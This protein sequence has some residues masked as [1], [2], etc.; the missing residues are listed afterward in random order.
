LSTVEKIS[1]GSAIYFSG[2]ALGLSD[3]SYLFFIAT[4]PLLALLERLPIS[5]SAI[6]IREGLFVI[7]FAPFY[8]DATQAISVAL[9]MR[10]SEITQI[11]LLAGVWLIDHQPETFKETLKDVEQQI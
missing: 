6:G 11:I 2:L 9:V 10:A 1:Y 8:H 5:I 4:T 7:L 3:V